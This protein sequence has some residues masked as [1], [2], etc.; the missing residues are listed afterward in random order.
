MPTGTR[1]GGVEILVMLEFVPPTC[2]RGGGYESEH[3]PESLNQGDGYGVGDSMVGIEG[4]AV[5]VPVL[6]GTGEI[7]GRYGGLGEV[8]EHS[9]EY[10]LCSGE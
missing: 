6:G 5:L 7:S 8:D 1:G 10:R 2:G 4:L 9:I 3:S